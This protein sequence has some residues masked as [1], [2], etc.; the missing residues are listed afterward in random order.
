MALGITYDDEID[1]LVIKVTGTVGRED[2]LLSIDRFL[3]HPKFRQNINQLFDCTEGDLDFT[4][5]DLESIASYFNTIAD[6]LGHDRKLA[7]VASRD[8]KFGMMRQY[9][10]FFDSG[11]SINICVFR[12]LSDAREWLMKD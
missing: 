4:T 7:I 12:S 10:A 6:Q 1:G 9:E 5:Q 2:I 8:L 11:P 3:N